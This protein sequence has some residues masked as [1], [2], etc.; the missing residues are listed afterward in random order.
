[1]GAVRF[2]VTFLAVKVGYRLLRN[3][4]TDLAL[5]IDGLTWYVGVHATELSVLGEVCAQRVY[6]RHPDF[7]PCRRWI[8]V[9]VGANVGAYSLLQARRGAHVIAVEPNLPVYQSL[10]H[11]VAANRMGTQVD[12]V[13]AALS[14]TEGWGVLYMP[15]RSTPGG[16]VVPLTA[17]AAGGGPAVHCTTL[18]LLMRDK[19]VAHIDLLK[20]D[21]EGAE[22]AILRGGMHT[23]PQ[24][25]R[26]Q[27]EYHTES[28]RQE[29]V[30]LLHAAGFAVVHDVP[31]INDIGI[32]Y[33]S[34]RTDREVRRNMRG[35][36]A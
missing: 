22:A 20:I 35:D 2:V 19:G 7:I 16:V 27:V 29:V 15:E 8:V 30:A 26:I 24:V 3:L 12:T 9:D 18:D 25:A 23:L 10:C 32:L 31:Q 36:D 33:A 6:D 4:P 21:A 17:Q 28:L 11:A 5:R 13:H 34:R 1:M 14:D